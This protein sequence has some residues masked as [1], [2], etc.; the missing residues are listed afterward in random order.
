MSPLPTHP[1]P[2]RPR[3]PLASIAALT[4]LT[5]LVTLS[6]LAAT[7][8]PADLS[9]LPPPASHSVAFDA[10]VLP[11]LEKACLRC[12]GPEK[13]K[14]G[15]RLD[16][17]DAALQ[18]GNSG[19]AILPGRSADSP[20]I[21]FI[22]GLV[23]DMEMPPTGKGDPLSPDDISILRAWI[24]QG[25]PW[26]TAPATPTFTFTAT[27]AV[28]F[29]SID[30]N[31]ARFREHNWNREGMGGGV[32]E[33]SVRYDLDPQ[34]HVDLSGRAVAGPDDYRFQ[35]RVRRDDL[36]WFRL[37]YREFSRFHDD[38]GLDYAP[39]DQPAPRLGEDLVVRHRRATAEFGLELPDWPAIR[40]A[41]DLI[42][43]EG[44]E[45]TLHWGGLVQN[46]TT[47]NIHP[48]RKQVDET[49]HLVT[50]DVR[51]DWNGTIISDQAQFEWH[52]Q[53]N[54]RTQFEIQGTPFDY[55]TTV[56]DRQDYW[57][58]ANVLRLERSIRDWL[59]V[60]GGYLYSQLRDTGGFDVS[61]FAP[62][63]PTTPPTL[64]IQAD[65]LTLRRRSHVLNA[66]TML[67]PWSDLH[68]HAGLQAE[69]T[70]QEGFATGQTY[71]TRNAFDANVDRAATDQT[72]GLRYAGIP[73]TVLFAETRF[74]QETYSHFE[75]GLSDDTQAFLRDTDAEGD[76]QDYEAGFTVSP[77]RSVSLQVKGR[78]R[79]RSNDYLHHR[80]VDLFSANRGIGYPAFI[81]S[82]D[83]ETDEIET[84]LVLQPLRWLKTT[85]KY[86]ISTTDFTTTT[87]GWEETDFF[88][89]PAPYPG[90]TVTAG[91]FDAQ[92]VSAGFV[93]T[94]WSR[95]LLSP[96]VGWT[97]S[98]TRS[99]ANNGAESVPYE[100]DSW[101]LLT[102]ATFIV[103]EKTDLLAS[104]L[105]NTADFS[106][107]NAA[108]GLPLGIEYSRHAMTAGIARRLKRDRLLR[109]EYGFF[110]YSEP[111]LGGAADYVAHALF[112]SFRIPW[113]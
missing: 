54:R 46:G 102:S 76:T 56:R 100:G 3:S 31:A 21:H 7:P 97:T 55:A 108:A 1:S 88:F 112:A 10:E 5:T 45:S 67:G 14:A 8:T 44:T 43:R 90:G 84:R 95:L 106:Q 2:H 62:S 52:E 96:T 101:T 40:L 105:F 38:T 80:D 66:N 19:P 15:F 69:W 60:S 94:P 65:D 29:I 73:L 70:R 110:E 93:L 104:Y 92:T 17:R 24:D 83:T 81:R 39:F 74:Q 61:S 53:D 89:P 58:G 63:D 12:H 35:A 25:A 26:S 78:H 51:Y 68:V 98:R 75:E 22:A 11:I 79:N 9:R 91:E 41:Y 85:L 20:L 47:R 71:G 34:T 64:D 23:E 16:H 30:G 36:G 77:W 82:R 18:G 33:F 48:A 32:S 37:A 87:D 86:A 99:S 4:P 28:Q 42:L 109:L 113:K 50:L 27:P 72:L 59:Y 49:T 13:P 111:S 103:D 57:R 107:N 6:S